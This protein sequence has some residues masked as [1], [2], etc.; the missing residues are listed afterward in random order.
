MATSL[1]PPRSPRSVV[2]P[3]RHRW[4]R[5]VVTLSLAVGIGAVP[6]VGAAQAAPVVGATPTVVPAVA[7]KLATT[8]AICRAMTFPVLQTDRVETS[9]LTG[10]ATE[11]RASLTKHGFTVDRGRVFRAAPRAAAGLTP[12]RRFYKA[13][14][15]NDFRWSADPATQRALVAAAYKNQQTDFWATTSQVD[16]CQRAVDEYTDGTRTHH[17]VA[18]RGTAL[19]TALT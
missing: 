3:A 2:A 12:V 9:L 14:K 1:L 8:G 7:S 5:A 16:T 15:V 4:L 11:S 18:L 19:A 10:W 6:A 13:G 17:R